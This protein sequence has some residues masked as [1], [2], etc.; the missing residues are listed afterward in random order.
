M[1]AVGSTLVGRLSDLFGRR[2]F[3]VLGSL[4]ATV[5]CIVSS[6]AKTIPV[7][8]GGNVLIGL[9]A[10]AQTS[11][12]FVLGELVPMKHRY[13][14]NGALYFFAIPPAAF[15]PA[16]AYAFVQNTSAGW[17]WCY[18]LMII[19][20]AISTLCWFFFYHPPT[21]HMV[22]KKTRSQQLREFDYGGLVLFTGGLLI[23]LMGLNWGGTVYPWKSGYV[24][25]TLVTGGV[26][27]IAFVLYECYVPLTAPLI[28]MHLFRN[29]GKFKPH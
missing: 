8:I 2:W 26:S 3:I 16:I 24:I 4:L 29:G 15:G 27:L 13:M 10:A 20:N 14:A 18:Y 1:I 6:Q 17:R 19:T 12:P 22:S 21:F 23:F 25:G 5:G 28:P 9:A 7:L 11:M